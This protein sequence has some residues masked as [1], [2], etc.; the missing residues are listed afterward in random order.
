MKLRL[1]LMSIEEDSMR[2]GFD[3]NVS[4]EELKE[5]RK[6]LGENIEFEEK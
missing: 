4:I 6:R 5:W 3:T 1:F 2:L